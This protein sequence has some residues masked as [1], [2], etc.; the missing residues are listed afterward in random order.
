MQTKPFTS[1]AEKESY[2]TALHILQTWYSFL[3]LALHRSLLSPI[4]IARPQQKHCNLSDHSPSIAK[5]LYSTQWSFQWET[6]PPRYGWKRAMQLLL[7]NSAAIALAIFNLARVKVKVCEGSGYNWC[8]ESVQCLGA[9]YAHLIWYGY[10]Q[11]LPLWP[12]YANYLTSLGLHWRKTN[13]AV[14]PPGACGQIL[15]GKKWLGF[16]KGLVWAQVSGLWLT[17]TT[18]AQP[19]GQHRPILPQ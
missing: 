6:L 13:S 11:Q 12:H 4:L 10:G 8:P 5:T 17:L 2:R 15:G 16:F 7:C 18:H 1:D 3:R 19:K 14:I 9:R